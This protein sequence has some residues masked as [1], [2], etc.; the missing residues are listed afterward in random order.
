[1]IRVAALALIVGCGSPA[2]RPATPEP[3]RS[4][5]AV[6]IAAA[7]PAAGAPVRPITREIDLVDRRIAKAIAAIDA[8]SSEADRGALQAE[9]AAARRERLALEQQLVKTTPDQIY[10]E[11]AA[12]SRQILEDKPAAG[13]DLAAL[14]REHARLG[15]QRDELAMRLQIAHAGLADAP[16]DRSRALWYDGVRERLRD[17]DRQ[18][19]EVSAK[20]ERANLHIRDAQSDRDREEAKQRLDRLRRERDALDRQIK[21]GTPKPAP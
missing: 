4:P 12:V 16:D 14:Q 8:A 18:L 3:T 7:T 6:P 5:V 21:S 11:L 20:L 2:A 17:S 9:L 19:V 10:D 1:M 15:G 13:S